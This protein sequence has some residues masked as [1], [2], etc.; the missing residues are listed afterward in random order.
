MFMSFHR[1]RISGRR[2]WMA[3]MAVAAAL[4]FSW[5]LAIASSVAV[6]DVTVVSVDDGKLLPGQ[7]VLTR[8]GRIVAVGPASSVSIPSDAQRVDGRNRYLVPGL[9]DMHVHFSRAPV[10]GKEVEWGTLD[11]RERNT[12]YSFLYIANGVTTVREMWG[13]PQTDELAESIRSGK[14]P[15]PTIYSTG[16]NTDGNPPSWKEARS[17][18][19]AAEAEAAVRADKA[20]GYVGIKVYDALTLELYR[21]IVDAAKKVDLP[22]MGHVPWAIPLEEVIRA[23]QKSIEHIDSFLT[24][25]SPE[26]RAEAVKLSG[27]QLYGGAID[28]GKLEHFSRAMQEA[29]IWVCPTIA[30]YQMEFPKDRIGTGMQYVPPRYFAKLIENFEESGFPEA[31][32]EIGYGLKVLRA[33][34]AAGVRLLPGTDSSRPNVVPG[35]ALHD[36]LAYFVA[37]GM[38]P[39]QALAAATSGPAEFLGLEHEFGRIEVGKR[40]DMILLE[41]NP[42]QDIGNLRRQ[43]GVVVRGE[44]FD[45]SRIQQQLRRFA[46][47]ARE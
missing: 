25:L 22:V 28:A 35:F 6:V 44:W 10:P 34:H 2:C 24:E 37:A 16:P 43:A 46:E 47:M 32:L 3:V 14:L 26:P 20:Q 39:Q 36:E 7:T 29:G 12:L 31:A 4:C 40:A 45:A 17:V 13:S 27:Q 11:H 38:T 8:D 5:S 21:A 33:F 18:T 30:V 41:A 9:A 42:L 19:N 23:R 15:G 1:T